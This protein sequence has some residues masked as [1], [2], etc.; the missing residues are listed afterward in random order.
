M[1]NKLSENYHKQIEI[2][3]GKVK[4]LPINKNLSL[5]SFFQFSS[6][7]LLTVCNNSLLEFVMGE[8]T[9]Q[10][11]TLNPKRRMMNLV[12]RDGK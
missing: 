9:Q 12:S 4:S 6:G 11:N 5:S 8:N 7:N 1:E 2:I 10:R 3:F